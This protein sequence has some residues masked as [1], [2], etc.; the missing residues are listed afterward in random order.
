MPCLV[1]AWDVELTEECEAWWNTLT[2]TEQES[3]GHGFDL[4][5]ELGPA[6]SRPHADT[7]KGSRFPNLKELRVQHEGRPYRVLYAFDPRR[8]ALLLLGGDKTG[9]GRWYEKA[10]PQAEKIYAKHLEELG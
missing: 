9:D 2:Q 4:L 3:V 8:V 7:L 6:L 10:I 1:M 5:A